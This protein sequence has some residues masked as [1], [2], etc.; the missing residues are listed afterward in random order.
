MIVSVNKPNR[1]HCGNIA[2][3]EGNASYLITLEDKQWLLTSTSQSFIS[4]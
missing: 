3:K 2:G 1:E 4:F